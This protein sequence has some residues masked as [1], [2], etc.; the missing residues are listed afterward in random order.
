MYYWIICL[1]AY[2][3]YLCD[4]FVKRIYVCIYEVDASTL[5]V[6]TQQILPSIVHQQKQSPFLYFLSNDQ[7][8]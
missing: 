5:H 8:M 6:G 2:C 7:A 3:W 1:I 4:T